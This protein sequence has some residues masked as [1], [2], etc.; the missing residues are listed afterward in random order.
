MGEGMRFVFAVVAF[1]L[2]A[3]SATAAEPPMMKSDGP[4]IDVLVLGTFHFDNPGQDLANSQVDDVL[5][6]K[7]QAEIADILNGLAR[8]KPTKIAVES[9][10]RKPGTNVSE[11]YAIYRTGK[12]EPSRNEVAQIGFALASRLGHRDVYAVDIPGDFPFEAVM[13]HAERTGRGA[14]LDASVQAIQ[15]FIA[16]LDVQLKTKTLGHIFRIHNDPKFVAAGNAFYLDVL[17]YGA[18]DEQPG[19]DLVSRWYERN[20]RICARIVQ[21]AEPGDR[22]LVLYGSGHAYLLRHCLGGVPGYRIVEGNDF[23]PD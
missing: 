8:F 3:V 19:A 17:R 20:I 10:R 12:A 15:A 4:P 1:T 9:Q 5:A 14:R 21:I 18:L 22:V 11:T 23:L 16:D 2:T 7:R 13:K 6:P